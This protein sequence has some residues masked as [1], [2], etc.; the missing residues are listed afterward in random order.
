MT[1]Y[2]S[3]SPII[4]LWRLLYASDVNERTELSSWS[5][6]HGVCT[7]ESQIETKWNPPPSGRDYY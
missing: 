6:Y 1:D 7:Q 2:L 5:I 4:S 3:V